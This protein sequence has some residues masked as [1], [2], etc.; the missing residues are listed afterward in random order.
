MFAGVDFGTSNSALAVAN[1]LDVQLI[2]IEEQH[3]FL[4]STLYT[5]DRSLICEY[6]FHNIAKSKKSAYSKLR[7]TQLRLAEQFRLQEGLNAE[8]QTV[9]FGR[10]AFKRYIDS[11]EEGLFIKSPKSFLGAT[12]LSENQVEIFEDLVTAKLLNIKLEAEKQLG[13]AITKVV[14]GRPVNFQGVNS[15]QSNHQAIQIITN[16]AKLCGYFEIEFVYEPIAAGIDFESKISRDQL[17]LV[18]DI[19]G[20]TTDCSLVH[21]GP[22]YVTKADRS[23]DFIAHS[24]R[25]VGGND[26]DI[27]LTFHQLMPLFGLE[28][29]QKNGLPV[30]SAPYWSASAINHVAE[31]TR[32]YSEQTLRQLDRLKREAN[33]PQLIER[34]IRLQK[35][36]LNYRLVRS[37]EEAKIAL[38]SSTAQTLGLDYVEAELSHTI[39]QQLFQHSVKKQLSE[40]QSLITDCVIQAKASPDCIYITGG[41]SKSPQ[42]RAAVNQVLPNCQILEGDYFGSVAAGLGKWADKLWR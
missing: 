39:S 27:A 40:V 42:V 6:I 31:Q 32:F 10:E 4:P 36:K 21:M 2:P 5:Y 23:L 38:S 26:F 13:D 35:N 15:E 22:S 18:V 25:R 33:Q 14:I 7:A 3:K 9:F 17:V 20:G 11:P 16:A 19:G 8:E 29:T 34:L 28:S 1:H 37:A 41:T 24:G 30:P 12:G